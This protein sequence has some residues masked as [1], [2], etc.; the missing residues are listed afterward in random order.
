MNIKEVTFEFR[1]M[2][3]EHQ[4]EKYIEILKLLI[5]FLLAVKEVPQR[6]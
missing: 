4:E 6:K 5:K 1:K 3:T 2:V